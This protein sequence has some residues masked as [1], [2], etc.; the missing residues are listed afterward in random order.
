M[1]KKILFN[2]ISA[3]IVTL[4]FG[5]Y[6]WFG[7]Q[8]ICESDQSVWGIEG[9][10]MLFATLYLPVIAVQGLLYICL[11]KL[12]FSSKNN[13]RCVVLKPGCILLALLF[14]VVYPALLRLFI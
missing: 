7:Y 5:V 13:P 2:T 1:T 11:R 3:I 12:W 4:C 6:A 9:D 10:I 14:L 8:A